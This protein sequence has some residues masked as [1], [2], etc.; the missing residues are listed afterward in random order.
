[1]STINGQNVPSRTGVGASGTWPIDITG[2]SGSVSVLVGNV[3]Y[4]DAVNGNDG[5][6]VRGRFDKPYL[7]VAAALAAALSGD[8]VAIRPGT[9]NLAA[10]I[11]IPSGV[12]VRGA[13]ANAVTLQM[14]AVVANT[15]LVTMG[16]DTRLED[17][18]LKLTSAGHFTLT[19]ILF[20]STTSA[21][22]KW[23]T[24]TLT[25]DNSGAGAG[26]SNVTGVLIQSTGTPDRSV[27]AI[28]AC[29]VTVTGANLGNKRG[30]LLNTS[31]CNF[32]LRDTNIRVTRTGA[33][34]SYIGV[35]SN[36]AGSVLS[37]FTGSSDAPDADISQT[38]GTLETD[39]VLVNN[40]T[41]ALNFT[42]L[43]SSAS[44]VFGDDGVVAGGITRY[45]LPGSGAASVTEIK[46]R[47]PR[48]CVAKNLMMRSSSAPGAAKTDTITVRKNGVDTIL[49]TNLSGAAQTSN[50]DS[51]NAVMF[52]AGDDI[53]VKLVTAVAT[54]TNDLMV[55]LELY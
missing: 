46:V 33:G 4:V 35:E 5:T 20:P 23:R 10:G 47:V 2:A 51:T 30:V 50:Q 43:K 9:Y 39:A 31:A 25:V 26:T 22:A 15:T 44:M 40:T 53:S 52:A 34:G 6:A 48:A 12:A 42:A 37:F 8:Q 32:S 11:T 29:T 54:G 18:A 1:M 28:R 41:N 21:S 13:S 24:A 49:T 55:S 45:M 38:L 17:A 27:N 36:F 7:T 3:L 16:T 14:L 19:G